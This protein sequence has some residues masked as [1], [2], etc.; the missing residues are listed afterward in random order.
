LQGIE[1]DGLIVFNGTF[2]EITWTGTNSEYWNGFNVA[3]PV[4]EPGSLMLLGTSVLGV[5]GLL[6]RKILG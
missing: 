5:A 1:G 6:R 3:A 2:S 4:P